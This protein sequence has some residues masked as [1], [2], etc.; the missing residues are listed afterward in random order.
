MSQLFD[1]LI[2][3]FT[4]QDPVSPIFYACLVLFPAFTHFLGKSQ[5]EKAMK[6][7]STIMKVITWLIAVGGVILIYLV[8]DSA[9]EIE[10]SD[11]MQYGDSEVTQAI[12]LTFFTIFCLFGATLGY[13]IYKLVS[14]GK[15]A[16]PALISLGVI[17]LIFIIGYSVASS[18]MM[19][20]WA[21]KG[22]TETDA[23][24]AS[25]GLWITS[26]FI[27][28]AI[29]TIIIGEVYRLIK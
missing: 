22:I 7:T 11:E 14:N 16:I 6:I 3:I 13:G 1:F 19:A 4:F 8:L 15:R 5:P 2:G 23:L 9:T 26:V 21:D 18:E 29:G 12:K 20:G 24:D 27:V 10:G 17:V 28:L 25:A